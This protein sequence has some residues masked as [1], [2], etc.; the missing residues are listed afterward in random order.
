MPMTDTELALL[1]LRGI[2]AALTMTEAAVFGKRE[3]EEEILTSLKEGEA[4]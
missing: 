1:E 3:P 4:Q 2:A